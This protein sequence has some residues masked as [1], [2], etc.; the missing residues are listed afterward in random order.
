M[1]DLEIEIVYAHAVE[2]TIVRVSVAAGTTVQEA[3]ERSGMLRCIPA[4]AVV[5]YGIFG[6]RVSPDHRLA[7]G[8]RI[9]CYRS[10][11][12]DPRAARRARAKSRR[13]S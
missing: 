3:L 5:A 11:Q 4:G 6:R 1:P 12:A 9:E 13:R 7:D 8:D 2:Q 10:L